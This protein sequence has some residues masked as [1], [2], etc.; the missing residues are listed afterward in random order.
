M[1]ETE[2]LS[3]SDLYFRNTEGRDR[4]QLIL[5]EHWCTFVFLRHSIDVIPAEK[6]S[7]LFSTYTPNVTNRGKKER[8]EGS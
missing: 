8:K 6:Q 2:F 5:A 4:T 7:S 1:N 3:R